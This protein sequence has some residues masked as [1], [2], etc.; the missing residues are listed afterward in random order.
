MESL[1]LG[2]ARVIEGASGPGRIVSGPTRREPLSVHAQIRPR[3]P[4]SLRLSCRLA[5]DATR[6][7]DGARLTAC[8]LLNGRPELATASQRRD[9]VVE[10]DAETDAAVERLRF[11]LALDD[12]HSE[13]LRRFAS[14]PML[15]RSLPHLAGLRPLRTGTVCQAVLRALAGQL[16][17]SRRA[18][19]IERRVVRAAA[20]DDAPLCR[21][22]TAATLARFSPAELCRFGLS[23]RKAATLV[24]LCRA[25]DLERLGALPADAVAARLERER[26]IGPWSVGVV[27]IEGLGRFDRGLVGDLGLV[28]LL[29]ALHGRW[30][31][32]W[33]T[34]ELLEPYC[35]WAGLASVYLLAARR[36]GLLPV[37]R[38]DVRRARAAEARLAAA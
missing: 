30:V 37:P 32:G 26:G 25:V 5:G 16:I 4:Y 9:G 34:A 17:D 33:E 20:P 14:D 7:F 3:G 35:E 21:P 22:P 31:E 6:R 29:A 12:D 1:L 28:K 15:G 27:F 2:D 36:G 13:F 24:R 8:V 23:A 10:V 19:A 18:R 38:D 11:V